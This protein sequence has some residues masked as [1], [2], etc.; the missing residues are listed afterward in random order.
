[1]VYIIKDAELLRHNERNRRMEEPYTLTPIFLSVG[2]ALLLSYIGMWTHP[3]EQYVFSTL[4]N[5]CYLAAGLQREVAAYDSF[6]SASLL[7]GLLGSAPY[8]LVLLGSASMTYHRHTVIG[9]WTHSLDIL[10]GMI[11]VFHNFYT[12]FSVVVMYFVASYYKVQQFVRIVMPCSFAFMM[13]VL[14][15][16]FDDVYGDMLLFYLIFGPAAAICSCMIRLLLVP[17][18]KAQNSI[19]GVFIAL[20]EILTLLIVVFAA[21]FA[22]CELIGVKY[23]VTS[24]PN[25][26]DF[27][28]GQW[29]FLI[30][31]S[32][33]MLYTRAAD[34]AVRIRNKNKNITV[35]ALS[36]ID[37]FG[38][39]LCLLYALL[40]LLLKETEVDL[41]TAKTT[42][43]W[44]ASLYGF[45]GL[46][47]LFLYITRPDIEMSID[48]FRDCHPGLE[49]AV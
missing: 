40:V 48:E 34:A 25:A 43:S 18:H 28:H 2:V 8:V 9:S 29:H 46:Y 44:F 7:V 23:T 31:L 39:T 21:I 4:T 30:S 3:D 33:A 14:M 17:G 5:L 47:A 27:Y 16:W 41:D 22:Q 32:M 19:T 24:N 10:F 13:C 1:M 12:S 49:C 11:L 38:L 15:I 36:T 37:W 45:Y 26:Y 20:A 35:R 42:L 6:H